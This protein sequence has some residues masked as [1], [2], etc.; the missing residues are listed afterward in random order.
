MN[1][2]SPTFGQM[3]NY[4]ITPS[5]KYCAAGKVCHLNQCRT[6]AETGLD[7]SMFIVV[8]GGWGSW[9]EWT[10]C[11]RTC[12]RGVLFRRRICDNPNASIDK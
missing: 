12:G 9:Q 4:P 7:L 1:I 10:T 11:S 2:G 5:G 3:V 8:P 6:W